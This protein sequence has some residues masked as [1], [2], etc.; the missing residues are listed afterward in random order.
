MKRFFA[1]LLAM[2]LLGSACVFAV[3]EMIPEPTAE[4][5]P[6]AAVS[7]APQETELPE[8]TEEP[9]APEE[10]QA[11]EE[12][13]LPVETDERKETPEPNTIVPMAAITP[14]PVDDTPLEDG[15]YDVE[16]GYSATMFN[17]VACKLVANGGAY[18]VTVTLSGTGYDKFFLGTAKEAAAASESEYIVYQTD[19]E[20][21]YT[22]TF[23]VEKLD[24]PVSIAAHAVKGDNWRDRKLSFRSPKKN[25]ESKVS[26][27]EYA[28]IDYVMHSSMFKVSRVDLK[29][30]KGKYYAILDPWG[31]P[32]C[33]RLGYSMKD[34]SNRPG[35]GM[36][37]DFDIFSRGPDGLGDGM[38][39]R[40]ENEDNIS[41]VRSWN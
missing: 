20:G 30:E 36:N 38:D 6:E 14:E 27:G 11:P 31:N 7:A 34:D 5:T 25:G 17:I 15:E 33:Y 37:S 2:L 35:K 18:T 19:G 26:D 10:T 40:D 32:Y 4:P 12:T 41:N 21:S 1:L 13:E 29:V 24:D 8:V 39:N 28:D 22:F 16:V 3:D 23:P 9:E